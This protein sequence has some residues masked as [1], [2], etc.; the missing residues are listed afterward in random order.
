MCF[1]SGGGGSGV[2]YQQMWDPE[3]SSIVVAERGVPLAYAKRGITSLAEYQQ[4][5]Q[6]ELSDRQLAAQKQIADQQLQFNQQQFD[7]QKQLDQQQQANAQAQAE[8][9]TTYDTGRAKLLGEGSKSIEDAFARFTP[10]YFNQYSQDYLGK[11][12]DQIDYQKGLAQKDITFDM[13]RRGIT[14]GQGNINKLGL[15]SEQEGRALAEQTD[16]AQGAANQLRSNVQNAKSNLLGQ[17]Q[18]S[19][20][21]GSPIA[22]A[23]MGSVNTALQTQRQ[24]IQGVQNQSGDVVASLNAVPT[25]SSL[26]S[27]FGNLLSGAGAYLGGSNAR[28]NYANYR[29]NAGLSPFA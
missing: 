28:A 10:D 5:A 8:R 4:A 19:E 20:S 25:V 6:Q 21:I 9:Q 26:G 13:A 2:Q 17:V 11:A 15:L 3:T 29:A 12:K 23:D 18:A 14:G 7:Y 27:L 24:A 1:R 16:A 22:G